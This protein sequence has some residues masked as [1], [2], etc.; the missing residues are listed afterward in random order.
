MTSKEALK[1]AWDLVH[2]KYPENNDEIQLVRYAIKM[3]MELNERDTPM[4]VI[5]EVDKKYV[6]T[7]AFYYRK[8]YKC[9]SCKKVLLADRYGKLSDNEKTNYCSHC[10]QKLDW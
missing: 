6:D 2:D 3:A 10:G 4:K 7:Y 5:L 8:T 9:G 1:K